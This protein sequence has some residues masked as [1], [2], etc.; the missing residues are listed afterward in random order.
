MITSYTA[1][2]CCCLIKQEGVLILASKHM[3]HCL[4]FNKKTFQ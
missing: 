2:C 4:F 3:I 1:G